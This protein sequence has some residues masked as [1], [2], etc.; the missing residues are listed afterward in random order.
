M[1]LA[2][3]TDIV[4]WMHTASG[5]S[6]RLLRPDADSISIRDIAAHLS[7]ICRFAGA[8]QS[9]YS[10]AQHSIL[11]S[12]LM[13]NYGPEAQLYGLLHDASEAYTGD[14][15][16]PVKA[17]LNAAVGLG[18]EWLPLR[19]LFTGLDEAIL[20]RVGLPFPVPQN[21]R[22]ALHH[23]DMRAMATERRD[24]LSEAVAGGPKWQ[25]MPA[26]WRASIKAWPW[27]KA[28]EK[29]LELFD[30]L[31]AMCGVPGLEDHPR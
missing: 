3:Q 19:D 26:P 24:L 28:E 31:A 9:F 4:P 30:D 13:A 25:D 15:P 7:K 11:V 10:V 21:L 2:S 27:P 17:L 5:R 6:V 1:N 14:I 16:Q 12:N 23:A 8:T 18:S 22:H 20:T 29:F